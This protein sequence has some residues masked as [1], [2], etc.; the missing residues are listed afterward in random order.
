MGEEERRFTR[1]VKLNQLY[2]AIIT[3]YR[4]YIEEH[5]H[6]SVAELPSL[7]TPKN[8]AVEGK[9][10]EIK[11]SFG[12]YSYKSSFKEASLKAF[13]FVKSE[14]EDAILPLQFWLTPEETLTF[15]TGDMI[16]KNVLLCS[17]LIS[18]GN[19]SAKV[20]VCMKDGSRQVYTYYEL[21]GRISLM[22]LKDGITEFGSKADMLRTVGAGEDSISY[23]FNDKMYVDL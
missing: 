3:R 23:E 15:L 14:I 1:E 5:E 22:E 4:D 17:L 20:L 7:V 11:S 16:D 10:A 18:L 13:E 21:D 19:P 6:L 12:T 8:G 9:A 2:L